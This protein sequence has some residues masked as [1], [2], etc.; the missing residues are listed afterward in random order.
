[1]KYNH[2]I[3]LHTIYLASALSF[4]ITPTP[5]LKSKTKLFSSVSQETTTPTT[6]NEEKSFTQKI[7]ENTSSSGQ[8]GGAGGS[9]TWD[10]FV[11]AEQL[12]AKL[13]QS[14]VEDITNN[15]IL[16]KDTTSSSSSFTFI[17]DDGTQGNT[18]AW[19]A[20]RSIKQ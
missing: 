19:E 17:T 3:L 12:W 11:R 7:M 6:K 4:H 9:S 5:T 18:K 14:S 16:D 10:A 1:M 2:S 13:K 20:L 15:S 8:T